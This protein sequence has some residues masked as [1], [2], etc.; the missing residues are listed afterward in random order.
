[1][2]PGRVAL[3]LAT[4]EAMNERPLGFEW[5]AYPERRARLEDA[6][7]IITRLW[8]GGFHDYDGHHWHLDGARLYTLPDERVPLF[9]AGNGPRTARVAGRYADGFLTLVDP[10]TYHEEL[11][12]ALA[13]GA[14]AAGRDPAAIDTIRQFSVAYGDDEAACREAAGFWRGSMAVDF[15]EDVADPRE[16]ECR[17][18]EL[19]LA[20]MDEWGLITT[21]VDDVLEVVDRHEDA[22]FDE[23]EFLS[24]LPD[25]YAFVDALGEHL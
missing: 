25:Q 5:P 20:E 11:A 10:D 19:P 13:D 9:V 7:E 1:M 22:G 3:T 23:I 14:A 18:R 17:G 6:C 16:V 21:D 24:A 8:D 15:Q 12:P 2:Y 4:G